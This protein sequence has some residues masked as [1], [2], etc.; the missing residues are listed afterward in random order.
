MN[1]FQACL[2][3]DEK[4]ARRLY[5]VE[6]PEQDK[7]SR[8]LVLACEFGM[9]NIAK[10]LYEFGGWM[11]FNH[12]FMI[13]CINDRLSVAKWIWSLNKHCVSVPTCFELA[14]GSGAENTAKW[15]YTLIPI[16]KYVINSSFRSACKLRRCENTAFWL[17]SLGADLEYLCPED[18]DN[19]QKVL[20]K[21]REKVVH[22]LLDEKSLN[23]VDKNVFNIMSEYVI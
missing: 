11:D 21:Q 3:G 17:Y 5:E 23:D 2:V 15:L 14:C 16:N 8:Y 18:R 6:K 12:V 7:L 19:F 22:V 4:I 10:M 1:F 20:Q 9:E 13:V